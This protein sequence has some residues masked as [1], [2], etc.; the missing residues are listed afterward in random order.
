M[1]QRRLTPVLLTLVLV[2]W[3]AALVS[4]TTHSEVG[5]IAPPAPAGS[6][7]SGPYVMGTIVD[8]GDPVPGAWHRLTSDPAHSVLNPEGEANGDGEPSFVLDPVSGFPFI[9]WA[10]STPQGFDVVGSAFVNGAWTTP[11]V[12]AGSPADELDPSAFLDDA[13]NVHVVYW[14]DDGPTKAVYHVQA[15]PDLSVWSVPAR[16]S[17]PGEAACR[18]AGA[19]YGG[20]VR[21]TYEVH[22]LGFG[23]TPRNVVLAKQDGTG[24]VPEIIAVTNNTSDV[25]PQVHTQSGRVWV[26]WIDSHGASDLEGEMAWTRLDAQ[27]QWEPKRYESFST[28]AERDLLLRATIRLKALQ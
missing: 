3:F 11:Q 24:F 2:A 19:V 16:V 6:V 21:V 22:T 28:R 20:V 25:R 14:V 5:V 4:P 8:D 10:R 12:L 15:P 9:T 18:P 13:G 26:E 7:L 17:A 1:S 23:S 27:G